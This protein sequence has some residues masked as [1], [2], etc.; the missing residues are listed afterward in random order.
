[1]NETVQF[2]LKLYTKNALLDIAWISSI[3]YLF[4]KK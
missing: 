4:L 1:M 2:I 3:P